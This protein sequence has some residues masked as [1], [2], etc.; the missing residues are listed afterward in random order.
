MTDIAIHAEGLSKRYRLGTLQAYKTLRDVI[1][2]GIAAPFRAGARLAR[3]GPA[4]TPKS[5]PTGRI[6][7]VKDVSFEVRRGEVLGVIGRNGAGKTTL[8]KLLTQITEPTE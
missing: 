7:A 8:L 4:R 5:E 1:G 3:G 6:W 2:D